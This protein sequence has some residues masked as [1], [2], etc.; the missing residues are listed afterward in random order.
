MTPQPDKPKRWRP[1]FSIRTL[2]I[3]V[4][5]VCV[6]VACWGPTKTWGVRDVLDYVASQWFESPDGPMSRDT[7]R[8]CA[9]PLPL[10]VVVDEWDNSEST[11][12]GM[13]RRLYFW[14][15]GWIVK[16]PSRKLTPGEPRMPIQE[17]LNQY[18]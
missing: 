16:L 15:F 2:V 4:T 3:L 17:D 11:G 12:M 14:C 10:I 7:S 6:Y 13:Y 9:V 8:P 18:D 1:R 5:L